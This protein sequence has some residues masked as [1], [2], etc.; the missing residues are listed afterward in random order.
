MHDKLLVIGLDGGTFD[1]LNPWMEDGTWPHLKKI[2]EE[3]M[4]G[5]LQS[6]IP[7]IT[8]P[9]S[10]QINPLIFIYIML[11][12]SS[13]SALKTYFYPSKKLSKEL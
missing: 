12:R 13:F 10:D 4:C 2:K 9:G 7:P 11:K 3:G 6:T 5:T 1:L 8:V